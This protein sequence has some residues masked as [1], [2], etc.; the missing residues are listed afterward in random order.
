MQSVPLE[1][2][3]VLIRHPW[4]VHRGSPNL[5]DTPRAL[6]SIRYVRRW[7]A[8]DSREVK[9]NPASGLGISDA[10]PAKHDALFHLFHLVGL[11]EALL[12]IADGSG[13]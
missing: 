1:I 6:V 13:K 4:A 11:S 7:Y 10:R 9:F 5:R 12:A 2:G 3:D 8:D